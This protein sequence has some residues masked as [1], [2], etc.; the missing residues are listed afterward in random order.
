MRIHAEFERYEDALAAHRALVEDVGVDPEHV[1]VRSPYP[2]PEAAI[3]PHRQRPMRLRNPVRLLALCGALAGFAL[4]AW[5]QEQVAIPTGGHPLV[6]LPLDAIVAYEC[7]MLSALVGTCVLFFLETRLGRDRS[8][9]PDEDVAVASGDCAIVVH[10]PLAEVAARHLREAPGVRPGIASA[11]LVALPALLVLGMLTGCKVRMR[12]QPS[13]VDGEQPTVPVAAGAVSMPSWQD[14]DVPGL[15]APL[16]RLLTREQVAGLRERYP[17]TSAQGGRHTPAA[18]AGFVNPIADDPRALERGRRLY[19]ENC[20][21]CH[22]ETGR[23]DGGLAE[24]WQPRPAHLARQD[25]VNES[26]G[27]LYWTISLAPKGMPAFATRMSGPDRFTLIRHLRALQRAAYAPARG[28][29][30]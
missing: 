5:T 14:P 22:G 27:Q 13:V 4:V 7:G 23:G 2:L 26:D 1:E 21:F 17:V 15:P 25:L 30:R 8:V 24:L 18:L 3:P 11:W 29:P 9:D 12:E 20:R 10:G 19:D 6:P 16:G 28:A